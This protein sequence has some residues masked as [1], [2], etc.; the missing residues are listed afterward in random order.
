[1]HR[2]KR[3]HVHSGRPLRH[4]QTLRRTAVAQ[5]PASTHAPSSAAAAEQAVNGRPIVSADED[6]SADG[7]RPPSVALSPAAH[8]PQPLPTG[9]FLLVRRL[10]D[11]V[12]E[13][14]AVPAFRQP[15]DTPWMHAGDAEEDLEALLAWELETGLEA[16]FDGL[17]GASS[18]LASPRSCWSGG[19][20]APAAA[21]APACPRLPALALAPTSHGPR[22][23]EAGLPSAVPCLS[24]SSSRSSSGSS[25]YVPGGPGSPSARAGTARPHP[26]ACDSRCLQLRRGEGICWRRQSWVALPKMVGHQS[27]LSAARRGAAPSRCPPPPNPTCRGPPVRACVSHLQV[28]TWRRTS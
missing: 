23:Q 18:P 27:Q 5:T 11:W 6:D 19:S 28:A 26:V 13:A 2:P 15:E 14:A 24:R 20:L 7:A 1:M 4:S 10:A 9:A 22:L 12:L 8:R 3:L 17:S 21:A 25:S 16:V